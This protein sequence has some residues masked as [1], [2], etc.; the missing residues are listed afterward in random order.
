MIISVFGSVAPLVFVGGGNTAV[1]GDARFK[2]MLLLYSSAEETGTG[3]TMCGI[4]AH[5]I[6]ARGGLPSVQ[7]LAMVVWGGLFFAGTKKEGRVRVVPA[8]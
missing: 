3:M 6:A 2:A 4:A 5:C 8:G 7:K 1:D